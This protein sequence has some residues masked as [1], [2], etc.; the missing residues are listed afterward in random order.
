MTDVLASGSRRDSDT[1]G[2]LYRLLV[3]NVTDYALIVVDPAGV[4]TSW[5]AGAQ[6]I[7]GYVAE[8]IL[9]RHVSVF[10]TEEDIRAGKLANELDVATRTGRFEDEGW[11]VRKDGARFWANVVVNALRDSDG[12]L[13]GFAKVTRDLSARRAAEEQARRLAAEEA[14]RA[15]AERRA[16]ELN[17]LNE[18]LQAQAIEL[19]AQTEEAQSLAEELE[20]S[21]ESLQQAT[22]DAEAASEAAT[23]SERFTRAVLASIQDA[24]IV[25]DADWTIAYQNP[26]A[27]ALATPAGEA[28]VTRSFADAYPE[29][30]IGP[31][32]D[33]LR[34]ALDR[35][36][37]A[38]IEARAP[39]QGR[40]WAMACAPL[41]GGL[42]TQWR[43]VSD[44]KR[45][46]EARRYLADASAIF[47]G[48]LDHQTTLDRFA[49]KVVPELA[50]WCSVQLADDTGRLRQVV[51]AHVDPTKEAWARQLNERYPAP[52]DSGTGAPN[53]LRTGRPE[54]YASISE[55]MLTAGAVDSEHLAIL[56]ELGMVSAMVIPL[57][58]HDRT[59]G[60]LTLVA[61]ES[62]RRYT[63]DDV[64][65]AMEL[66]RRA[67]LAVDN[68][69]LHTAAIEARQA[70]E[71]A[72]AVKTQFLA[73]MSHE[74][75]TPLNA[76]AGYTELL[77]MGLRGPVT[78]EQVI[79]LDRIDRS[80]RALLSVINDILNFARLDA[81]QVQFAVED[82]DVPALIADVEAL[83]LPQLH[84]KHLTLLRPAARSP[85]I[86]RADREKARQVLLN[87]L[88]NA[89]KFTDP[90]GTISIEA[91]ADGPA[92]RI[93]VVDTGHGIASDQLKSIFEPFVQLDRTLASTKEGSGLGLAISRDLARG[94]GGDLTVE[95]TPGTGSRFT[96][97]LP[98]RISS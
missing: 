38:T 4:V 52:T 50:D 21:T 35:R 27:Q 48:S 36:A 33:T 46:D 51:V 74:L 72:N 17:D 6:R 91:S 10:Y 63:E 80:Q 14:A 85:I 98:R 1:V 44:R 59:L 86:A 19:E 77:R 57:R 58:A 16:D 18:Q 28:P 67:A 34:E 83:V 87:L 29:L 61:A 93:D 60:V 89:I 26:A 62:G 13:V 64:E 81:G 73:V 70:A 84:D 5:N 75:R 39:N 11:R 31:F 2:N 79:D 54:L 41:D 8:E 88:S 90:G 40:W 68:A 47:A 43:D 7:T 22:L 25:I 20:Q 78:R 32:E 15:E 55:E 65:L 42:V 30:A 23:R 76:I 82:V 95:S 71:E 37:P 45:A 92:A 3:E 94:M 9:G 69:R 12:S 97:T 53:V 66:G 49:H 96:L 56:R 24:V